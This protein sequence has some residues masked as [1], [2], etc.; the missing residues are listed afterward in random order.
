MAFRIFADFD[1]PVTEL[2]NDDFEFKNSV[3]VK[4]AG[5]TPC[6]SVLTTTTTVDPLK[7]SKFN[8]K[9]GIKWNGPN[10]FTLEKLEVASS[11]N[12]SVETSLVNVAPG[13]KFEYKGG[14]SG[15]GTGDVS[16]T[17]KHE[18]AVLTAEA[19]V[20]HFQTAKVSVST[21]QGPFTGGFSV[22]SSNGK[23]GFNVDSVDAALGYTAKNV[24]GILRADNWASSFTG[25]V[26]Y[27]PLHHVLVGFK[28]NYNIKDVTHCGA[29]V[30]SYKLDNKTTIKA[31]VCSGHNIAASVKHQCTDKC[32]V[33]VAAET[34]TGFSAF[35][36]GINAV[37]G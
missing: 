27:H 4:T 19:D 33:G 17:Y 12:V 30:G 25:L 3:K 22:K 8:T 37:I 32:S 10:G 26:K 11:G 28:A 29:L 14:D 35:K 21:G 18:K 1:K 6:S 13:L 15:K 31:K 7:E 24:F 5:F 2:F 20:L 23:A 9:F 36:Y 34:N 16:A